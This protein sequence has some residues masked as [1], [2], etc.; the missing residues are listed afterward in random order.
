[1]LTKQAYLGGVDRALLVIPFLGGIVFGLGPFL[2]PTTFAQ[3]SG[4]TGADPYIAQLAGAATFGY[5]VA[6]W[7]ALRGTHFERVKLVVIATLTFN[8]ASIVS[9]LVEI[10]GGT[11]KPVVFLIFATSIVITAITAKVLRGYPPEARGKPDIATWLVVILAIATA[12]AI[13]FG[14]VPQFPREAAALFGYAGTDGF[15]YRQAAAAT[16]GYGVMGVFE[17][18]SRSF[19]QIQ[20]PLVMAAVFNG[21]SLLASL[22]QLISGQITLLVGVV[23]PAALLVSAGFT[24][25]LLRRGR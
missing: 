16:L 9:C 23:A 21:L 25:A 24:I 20:L 8:V 5:A 14:I 3:I 12:A 17:L 4:Y 18:R 6:L 13:V 15:L 7:P 11:A 19:E 1:M 22:L 2:I 10:I